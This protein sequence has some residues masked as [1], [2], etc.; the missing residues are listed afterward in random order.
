MANQ[1]LATNIAELI[2][3]ITLEVQYINQNVALGRNLV[4]VQDVDGSIGNTVEFPRFT[5][6]SGSTGP[7]EG[8]APTYHTMDLS[9][10]T[11]TL[12]KRS[13]AIQLSGLAYRGAGSQIVSQIGRAMALAKAKQDDKAIFNIVT[14]TT[15]WA[16]STG[17]TNAALTITNAL[18]AL[19]VLQQNE[20]TEPISF[21]T[22][23]QGY[24]GIRTAL[25]PVANDDGVSGASDVANEVMRNALASRAFGMNWYVTQRISSGTV[26]ATTQVW[27]SLAFTKSGI[28]YAH[29]WS[30]AM[31]GVE[32]QRNADTDTWDL[33][34]NYYDSAIVAYASNV[35]KVAHK[36]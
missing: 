11:A 2:P 36:P 18:A 19:L 9:M 26:N 35:C 29:A 25:T 27:N 23:A 8:T 30:P 14:A 7:A 15:D 32:L 10:P 4:T 17:Q 1:T 20:V 28:G 33:I 22:N 24:N 34:M 31:M 5:E 16:T 21:V 13:V 12:G 6:V 3:E